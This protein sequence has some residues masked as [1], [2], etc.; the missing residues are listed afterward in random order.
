MR[1]T[2]PEEHAGGG[3]YD[4]VSRV[5]TVSHPDGAVTEQTLLPQGPQLLHQLPAEVREL[6]HPDGGSADKNQLQL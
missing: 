2:L 1:S 4:F 5:G 6:H 3:Q